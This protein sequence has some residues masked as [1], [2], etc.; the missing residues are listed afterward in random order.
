MKK[1]CP[2]RK[3]Q[4]PAISAAAAPSASAPRSDIGKRRRR[5]RPSWAASPCATAQFPN[6]PVIGENDE[7]A[8]MEVLR[9]GRW[10]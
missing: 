9:K 7:K 5:H 2:R 8:W 10:C 3:P 4:L 6:W 1:P